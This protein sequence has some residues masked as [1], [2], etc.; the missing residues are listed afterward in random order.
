MSDNVAVQNQNGPMTP[1][2]NAAPVNE[3]GPMTPNENAAPVNENG[4]MIPNE[5]AVPVVCQ[6]SGTK[7]GNR[8]KAND[9]NNAIDDDSD[10]DDSSSSDT[11]SSDSSSDAEGEKGTI[12][13]TTCTFFSNNITFP[14]F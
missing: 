2:E 13:L 8:A 9:V 6:P 5:N 12:L 7:M 11:S 14:I 3:S 1:N 10:S 4:H